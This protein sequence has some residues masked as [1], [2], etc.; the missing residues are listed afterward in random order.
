MKKL[1][2]LL[3]VSGSAFSQTTTLKPVFMKSEK[4]LPVEEVSHDNI[5]QWIPAHENSLTQEEY[6]YLT[7]GLKV[8]EE[9]GLDMKKGYYFSKLLSYT[10]DKYTFIGRVFTKEDDKLVKAFSFKI[11]SKVTGNTYYLAMPLYGNDF[12]QDYVNQVS[13]FEKN[14]QNAYSVYL[15]I[16]LR[17]WYVNG[18][19]FKENYYKNIKK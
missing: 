6:N 4:P 8:Q 14:L 2:L 3:L 19:D 17:E 12:L 9:S 5:A 1:L 15:S 7:K 10:F 16:A 18:N 13:N 11:Q